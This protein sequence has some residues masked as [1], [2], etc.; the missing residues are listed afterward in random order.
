MKISDL[1]TVKNPKKP[2]YN[3]FDK[4]EHPTALVKVLVH[5][6]NIM[7]YLSDST[8][9]E[10]PKLIWPNPDIISRPIAIALHKVNMALLKH[11]NL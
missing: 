3:V 6:S 1:P 2:W 10:K 7:L 8:I 4:T 11:E 9:A 5:I